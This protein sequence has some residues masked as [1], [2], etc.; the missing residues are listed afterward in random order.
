MTCHPITFDP[1]D[2]V[3]GMTRAQVENELVDVG[4]R[5]GRRCRWRDERRWFLL[6][7]LGWMDR[8]GR[9][10]FTPADAAANAAR[11]Q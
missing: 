4:P 6:S 8:N 10:T 5:R 11:A 1:D 2:T 7:V 9:D 3:V